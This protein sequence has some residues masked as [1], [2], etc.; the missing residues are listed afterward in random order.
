MDGTLG[1]GGHAAGLLAGSEPGG[2]LLGLDV[3]PQALDLARQKLAPFGERAWL[4]KASYTSLPDQL[5]ELGWDIGGWHPARPGRLFHAVRHPGARL[6]LPGRRPAGH[7]L[8]PFEPAHRRRD[9]Q[10]VAGAGTG[11]HAF[12]LR[13]GTRRPAHRPGHRRCPARGAGPGNWP[14]SSSESSPGE[15]PTTP[16][17]RPS[18]P[19]ASPS[20]ANW[21]RWR[22]SFHWRCRLS[23]REAGWQSSPSTRWKTG[24]SKSIF[25]GKARTASAHP[26]SRSALAGIKQV[27]RKSPAGPSR[28]PRQKSTR[29]PAH[30]APSYVLLRN[31]RQA[32]GCWLRTEVQRHRKLPASS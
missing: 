5:A 4:K 16:P 22:K 6:L 17:R 24:S 14:P 20:T 3:D 25:A 2:Q 18:R 11:R 30:A 27:S 9:R 21:S 7:A 32:N 13:G 31:Y 28:R 23:V 26:A 19:C 15:V 1:A 10:Q 12:P 8:R 29:I